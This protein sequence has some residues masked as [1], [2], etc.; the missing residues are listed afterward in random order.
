MPRVLRQARGERTGWDDDDFADQPLMVSTTTLGLVGAA[1][2]LAIVGAC[3]VLYNGLRARAAARATAADNDKLSA[4]LSSAPA[5]AMVVRADG[6]LELPDRLADWLGLSPTPRFL[7]ELVTPGAGLSSEDAATLNDAVTAAQ[8]AGAPFAMAIRPQGSSRTLTVQGQ[9]AAGGVVVW[10]FDATESQ[11]QIGELLGQTA[12]LTDAFGALMGLIEAAPLPMWYRGPDLR[13]AMVNSAY[14][15]A[16][17]GQDAR[18]VVAR[19]VE[20]IEGSG[21]GGPLANAG[22]A[23]DTDRPAIANA[24]ATI[25]GARKMLRVHDVPLPSPPGGVAGFAID[26]DE[27]E[28]ARGG[29]KR[30]AEAQR[31]MLDRLSAGV[32]QFT[33]DRTLSFCNEPFMRIFAM[34]G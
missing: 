25:G 1:I 13:L 18:D 10:F 30:F 2:A 8:K 3:W 33:A 23:R 21:T 22:R 6:R 5:L 15:R 29:I 28:Q 14:V 32:A 4:L 20:L 24:P 27:L 19:G 17:E 16:V 31:A 7:A 11:A 26:I 12:Q 9:R 34:K